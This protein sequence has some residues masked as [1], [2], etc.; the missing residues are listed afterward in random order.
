MDG[1]AGVTRVLGLIADSL[2][3]L[4]HVFPNLLQ[5]FGLFIQSITRGGRA[6]LVDM[7]NSGFRVNRTH[8][9][10]TAGPATWLPQDF[11]SNLMALPNF[12]RLYLRKGARVA[13]SSAA[14]QE[15]RVRS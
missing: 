14:W 3:Q 13:L 11:L 1:D 6:R 8:V 5:M 12:M 15:I 2:A 9:G 10:G 4:V 7:N